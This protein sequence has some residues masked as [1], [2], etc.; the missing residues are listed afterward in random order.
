MNPAGLYIHIPFCRSKCAYCSFT[1]Y[2]CAGKDLDGYLAALTQ[3][4]TQMAT[5][6]WVRERTFASLFIGGGTPTVYDGNQLA[7]LL[8]TCRSLF[9]FANVSEISIEANP[10]TLTFKKLSAL[11][12]AGINRLSIGIQS[13]SGP[14]LKS[15]GRS[16]TAA[17]ASQSITMAREAGFTNINLDLIYGLPGQDGDIWRETLATALDFSPEHLALYELSI[18]P[19]TPFAEAAAGGELILPEE[20]TVLEMEQHARL[21]LA[22]RGYH[23]YEISNYAQPG[24]HCRHNINYWQNGS[25]LGLG[26][27]AVSNFSG[28]RIKNLPDPDQYA[29]RIRSEKPPYLEGEGLSHEAR[30]RETVIM[31]M[32]MTAG[33]S[34]A[35][36]QERFRLEPVSYYGTILE[37][38]L[39]NNLVELTERHLRLTEKGFPVANQVLS[40]LV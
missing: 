21:S 1:S 20:E 22:E 31:G 5:H 6:P 17:D 27:G 13:F 26:A 38:L 18:E 32:R 8:K 4:A 19:G 11:R 40:Q 33:V 3:Q 23:H 7:D 36:L 12:E 24:R 39:A 34:L 15:I 14:V 16:H 10:N 2:P 35:Q 37:K 9:R 28:L 30:F 29:R 25:Y